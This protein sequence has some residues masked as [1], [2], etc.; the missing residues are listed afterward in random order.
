MNI[1]Y[2]M[3]PKGSLFCWK[4]KKKWWSAIVLA[5]NKFKCMMASCAQAHQEGESGQR[6]LA[7]GSVNPGRRRTRVRSVSNQSLPSGI[8][9]NLKVQIWSVFHSV[10]KNNKWEHQYL[11]SSALSLPGVQA[12]RLISC[13]FTPFAPAALNSSDF[14]LCHQ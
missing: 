13:N 12:I 5:C 8:L 1:S 10:E 7:G 11:H 14:Y 6:T 2:L 3:Q 4:K 9:K